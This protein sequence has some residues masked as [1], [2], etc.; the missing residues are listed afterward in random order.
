MAV[1]ENPNLDKM[2]QAITDGDATFNSQIDRSEYHETQ[3][4]VISQRRGYHNQH[5]LLSCALH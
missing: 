1:D 5:P 4:I 2:S 3:S